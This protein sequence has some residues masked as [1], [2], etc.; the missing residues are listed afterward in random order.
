MTKEEIL[1]A[2]VDLDDDAIVY[3]CIDGGEP[4]CYTPQEYCDK[5]T[6]NKIQNEITFICK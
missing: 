2:M 3:V 5:V 6:G 1:E 4:G